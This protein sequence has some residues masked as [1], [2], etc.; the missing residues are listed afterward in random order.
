MLYTKTTTI[1]KYIKLI[2]YLTQLNMG[3]TIKK[4]L[5]HRCVDQTKQ[6]IRSHP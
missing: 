5:T 4:L 6:S 1:G 3:A 2:K